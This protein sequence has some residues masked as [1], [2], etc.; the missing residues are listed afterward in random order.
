MAKRNDEE[1]LIA[2]MLHDGV[3][4]HKK[5]QELISIAVYHY[6]LLSI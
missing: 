3:K 1:S 5:V 2:Y 4:S 6:Y